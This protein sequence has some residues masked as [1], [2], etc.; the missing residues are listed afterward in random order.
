MNFKAIL[1]AGAMLAMS[2]CASVSPRSFNFAD[3]AGAPIS[4]LRFQQGLHNW[5]RIDD[6]SVVI[7]TRPSESYL[8]TLRVEC[9]ALR[10]AKAVVV[11]DRDGM[12][13]RIVAGS[14]DLLA[15]TMRCRIETIRPIDQE[16]LRSD[17]K[18]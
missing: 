7:W 1:V 10:T 15:G 16:R 18:S 12:S 5:Q 8:L 17:Q 13:G 11:D 4:E 2:A 6:A 9:N 14:T 3:Y